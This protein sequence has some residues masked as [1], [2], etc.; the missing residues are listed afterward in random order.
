[1]ADSVFFNGVGTTTD[2]APVKDKPAKNKEPQVETE[3]WCS[4]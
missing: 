1:V 3:H 4:N 2:Y